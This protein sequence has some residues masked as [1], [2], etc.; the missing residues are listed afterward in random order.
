MTR[1]MGSS[2]YLMIRQMGSSAY[3]MTQQMGYSAYLGYTGYPLFALYYI[4]SFLK[5]LGYRCGI[6][7]DTGKGMPVFAMH[8]SWNAL[9][10]CN[11]CD[12]LQLV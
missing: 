9:R 1:Q 6:R 12:Y 4:Y 2:A 7:P 8:N 3:L 10:I 5:W 11:C